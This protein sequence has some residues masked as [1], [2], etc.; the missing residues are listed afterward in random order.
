MTANLRKTPM[1]QDVN[2][3]KL[4]NFA[5]QKKS[6]V[7]FLLSL[8]FLQDTLRHQFLHL[9]AIQPQTRHSS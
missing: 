7:L 8:E 3:K 9:S 1:K 5:F 4:A 6:A 2:Q